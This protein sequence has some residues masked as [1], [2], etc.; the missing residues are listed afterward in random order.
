MTK[1]Y[2]M[3]N[4]TLRHYLELEFQA[5]SEDNPSSVDLLLQV[6]DILKEARQHD[7]AEKAATKSLDFL[8][9]E[10][11]GRE[12]F[13]IYLERKITNKKIKQLIRLFYENQGF[14]CYKEDSRQFKVQSET[15]KTFCYFFRQNEHDIQVT[16]TRCSNPDELI[17]STNYFKKK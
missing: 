5:S 1:Y 2:S 16:I 14:E 15:Y 9:L 10:A 12:D 8:V 6:S 4:K 17:V 3:Q 11:K 7:L 13:S